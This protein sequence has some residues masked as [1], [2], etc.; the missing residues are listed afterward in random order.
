M[1][2]ITLNKKYFFMLKFHQ[3][4]YTY[5]EEMCEG[6]PPQLCFNADET[7]VE[8]GL[9]RK[10]IIPQG[11]KEGHKIDN[12]KISCHISAMVTINAAGDDFIP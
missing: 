5:S 10:V 3:T 7:S 2:A 8:I 9:P 6:V 1:V 4:T 12:F 11:E